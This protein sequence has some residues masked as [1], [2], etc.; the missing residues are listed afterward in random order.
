LPLWTEEEEE[1]EEEEKEEEEGGEKEK[2][3]EKAHSSR[4]CNYTTKECEL[5]LTSQK[6][7]LVLERLW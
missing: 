2:E 5:M 6:K 4:Y 1:E 3:E 7:I